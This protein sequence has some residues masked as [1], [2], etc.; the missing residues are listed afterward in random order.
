MLDL[1]VFVVV[2]S[3]FSGS[4]G[5][6]DDGGRCWDELGYLMV[7]IGCRTSVTFVRHRVLL[8]DLQNGICGSDVGRHSVGVLY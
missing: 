5:N 7:V 8:G 4:Y 2:A 3:V 6:D 1:I